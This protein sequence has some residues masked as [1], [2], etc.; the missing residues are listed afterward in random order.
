MKTQI[1]EADRTK[2]YKQ[3]NLAKKVSEYEFQAMQFLVDTKTDI[4]IK[5]LR[6][7]FYFDTDKDI[8]N[9]YSVTLTNDKH[10]FYFDFGD[11]IHNTE[12]LAKALTPTEKRK[13]HPKAYDVLSCLNIDY[14]ED[15]EDFCG[16]FGYD[17][18]DE[19]NFEGNFIN[20]SA[21]KIYRA[22]QNESKN[23]ESLFDETQLEALSEI[24]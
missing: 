21:M 5:F 23:L 14:S 18:F 6:K 9:I 7:G 1:R 12:E 3:L 16:N 13:L 20:E 19:D 24:Q 11:S 8:R 17:T 15:F 22:V 10:S 4:E 2:I